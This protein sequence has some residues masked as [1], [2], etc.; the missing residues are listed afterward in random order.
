MSNQYQTI[1]YWKKKCYRLD[2]QLR[3]YKRKARKPAGKLTMQDVA[4]L[5]GVSR[6]TVSRDMDKGLVSHKEVVRLS[7]QPSFLFTRHE[8]RRYAKYKNPVVLRRTESM[9]D[10]AAEEGVEAAAKRFG[11][12]PKSVKKAIQRANRSNP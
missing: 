1:A 10:C 3:Q 4:N 5:A 7:G 2:R 6:S 12:K 11:I 8:A 9:L